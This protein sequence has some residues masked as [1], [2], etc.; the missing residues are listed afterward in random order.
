MSNQFVSLTT[1]QKIQFFFTVNNQFSFFNRKL[2]PLSVNPT[3]VYTPV[4]SQFFALLFS[5]SVAKSFISQLRGTLNS[6]I[7]KYTYL[8]LKGIGF[9]LY[10]SKTTNSI[11]VNSGYNHYTK[12]NFPN[13]FSFLS[14]KVYLIC[15]SK[16]F[17]HNYYI[18]VIKNVRSPDPYRAKGFRFK[19]QLIKLKVG[20]QR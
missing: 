18:N 16:S 19:N 15:Y 11:V 3:L 14:R 2:A 12:L 13:V 6:E 1:F 9:K 4:S 5:K 20:K 8:H 7:F 10:P 17:L